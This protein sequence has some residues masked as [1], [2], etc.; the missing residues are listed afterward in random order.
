MEPQN[1]PV[2][3]PASAVPRSASLTAS[4]HDYI[5][6]VAEDQW[7]SAFVAQD[8]DR[9]LAL[10]AADIVYMPADYPA[11]RGHAALRAWLSTFPPVT[12]F[13]QPIETIDGAG[14]V[15]VARAS[16]TVAFD[17]DGQRID[18]AGKALCSLR[19]SAAGQ[20]LVSAVCWN[21][22]QPIGQ[23]T[24]LSYPPE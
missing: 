10:C 17:V 13:T 24:A 4:D 15:A 7:T 21:F 20:W 3:A 8:F 22:D 1:P 5:R 23:A 2:P 19:R 18:S 12:S 9:M 16:F 11:L 6:S 14:D